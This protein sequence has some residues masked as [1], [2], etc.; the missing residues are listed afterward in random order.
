MQ[1][2][3]IVLIGVLLVADGGLGL[4]GRGLGDVGGWSATA[5]AWAPVLLVVALTF[6]GVQYCRS[7]LASTGG[8]L[9]AERLARWARW[10]LLAHFTAVVLVFGWLDTVRAAVG[11]TV[12]ADEL[13]AML[14]P[15]VGLA[16]I[17][18]AYYPIECRVREAVLI[19]HLDAGRAVFPAPTRGR[20]V[21]TQMRLHVL[22]LLVP[23]LLIIALAELIDVAAGRWGWPEWAGDSASLLAAAIVVVFAP[24]LTRVVLEVEPVPECPLKDDLDRVCREHGV[25][26]RSL[27]LWHT[28][29][30]M[31]NA[32]V[33]GL[34][35]WLRYVLVT[36]ALLDSMS[37]RQVEAVMAHE[38][39]HI[40]RHHMPW[41]LAALLASIVLAVY[42]LYRVHLGLAVAAEA[43]GGVAPW[44][45]AAATGLIALGAVAVFCVFGWVSR[46]FERQADT[47]A[48]WHLSRPSA[49]GAAAP[50]RVTAEAAATMS[51]A[52]ETIAR[53]N[54]V[55]QRRRSWRHGSIAWRRAYLQRIVD[56]PQAALA[57][58]RQVRVIKA[59][60]AAVLVTAAGIGV[61]LAFPAGGG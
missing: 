53:L 14:P 61:W 42:P 36:D 39:G 43:A 27:L 30:S 35:G 20:Y 16:G 1:L 3:A 10:L 47:F 45:D 24:L 58:D 49:D 44:M 15:L 29:G 23:I 48:A 19:R 54:A 8:V 60:S 26:I 2:Y 50:R 7:R 32:A 31:I 4:S 40:R 46:R 51:T 28:H 41:L 18:W 34:V 38:I 56:R 21:W 17:W 57:I 11:D 37:R 33:M 6:G 13:I 55:P 5:L 9:A 59:L 25:R 52:L 12:L 22:F